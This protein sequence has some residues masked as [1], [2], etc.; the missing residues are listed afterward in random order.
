M[1]QRLW[2]PSRGVRDGRQLRP[3]GT[4]TSICAAEPSRLNAVAVRTPLKPLGRHHR[5]RGM[6]QLQSPALPFAAVDIG[7]QHPR[8]IVISA[9]D[10]LI[11]S[12]TRCT[13][14]AASPCA[15]SRRNARPGGR[16]PCK[17]WR[18]LS[19]TAGAPS[20]RSPPGCRQ[21]TWA[22]TPHTWC[23]RARSKVSK[24]R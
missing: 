22:P 14:V 16:A 11:S 15:C 24:A 21:A 2:R 17:I 6:V 20:S 19:S 18:Q 8:R 12:S 4:L 5:Q 7:G 1:R 3:G 10:G 13:R 9:P 23:I